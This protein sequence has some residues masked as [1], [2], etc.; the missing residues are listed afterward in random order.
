MR[1]LHG[2]TIHLYARRAAALLGAAA[3]LLVAGAA[4]L[5]AASGG[6]APPQPAPAP[7]A[8]FSRALGLSGGYTLEVDGRPDPLAR[9]FEGEPPVHVVVLSGG[10]AGF[11]L[12][13]ATQ[14]VRRLE[15]KLV[16]EAPP[17][18]LTLL[19]GAAAAPLPGG[20]QPDGPGVRFSD[21]ARSYY[22][23]PKPPLVGEVTPEKILAY[24]PEYRLAMDQYS[25]SQAA[26][27][28]IRHCSS[29]SRIEVFYG[30]WCPFCRRHVPRL[31]KALEMA[32]GTPLTSRFVALPKGFSQEKAAAERG[33]QRVPTLIVFDGLREVGRLQGPDW[34]RP[35]EALARILPPGKPAAPASR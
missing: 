24:S 1:S 31:L 6:G 5:P 29:T 26:V 10:G 4:P 27:E 35:E 3:L 11:L 17:G 9:F 19:P 32:K 7:Q 13:R 21:A 25:P 33:V 18:A 28:A 23:I 2:A 15:R 12:D 34:E 22:V 30:S 14:S 16:V 20:Y 8:D